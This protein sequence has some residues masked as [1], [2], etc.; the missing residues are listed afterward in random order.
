MDF[1][2]PVIEGAATRVQPIL[3]VGGRKQR[4]RSWC[5]IPPKHRM[6]T[7]LRQSPA[8]RCCS[9]MPAWGMP[10]VPQFSALSFDMCMLVQRAPCPR[11]TLFWGHSSEVPLG[12]NPLMSPTLKRQLASSAGGGSNGGSA[13][14]LRCVCSGALWHWMCGGRASDL[15]LRSD[16]I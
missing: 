8:S 7:P 10:P 6:T 1:V 12:F 4:L 5:P 2:H 14:S 16:L 3:Q 13:N 11:V 15:P 9:Q